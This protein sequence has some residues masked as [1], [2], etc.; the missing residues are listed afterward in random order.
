MPNLKLILNAKLA[1]NPTTMDLV[2]RFLSRN[3]ARRHGLR[4]NKEL[5]KY[6]CV[7][8]TSAKVMVS[9]LSMYSVFNHILFDSL[10][11]ILYVV[12]G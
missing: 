12:Q 1:F 4:N 10:F 3:L 5:N 11:L 6:G 8:K 7:E 9:F 2:L